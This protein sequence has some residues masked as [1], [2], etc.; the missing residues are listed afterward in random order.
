MNDGEKL[1]AVRVGEPEEDLVGVDIARLEA[2]LRLSP[3]Q[4]LA[5]ATK[6]ANFVLATRRAYL[7]TVSSRSNGESNEVVS[8]R[9]RAARSKKPRPDVRDA[10]LRDAHGSF[11]QR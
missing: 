5:R 7:E 6:A 8:N 1:R 2:N 9:K 4:R 11:G 10:G 3:S